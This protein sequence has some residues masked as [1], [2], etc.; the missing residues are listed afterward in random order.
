MLKKI[1][2]E[3]TN[4]PTTDTQAFHF[5]VICKFEKSLE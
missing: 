5:L 4:Q 3:F 1:V 2:H